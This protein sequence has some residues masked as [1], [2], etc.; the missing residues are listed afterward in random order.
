MS[1]GNCPTIDVDLAHIGFC[2][3][4]P[5]QYDTG[6]CLINL[7]EINIIHRESGAVEGFER[8]GNGRGQHENG[9]IAGQRERDKASARSQSQTLGGL[10]L[11]DEYSSRTIA[12]LRRVASRDEA[13]RSEGGFEA[14]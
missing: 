13:I 11:H 9:I 12:N 7:D 14:G 10:T 3:A 6:E 1:D 4:L 8:G 2:F 5:C